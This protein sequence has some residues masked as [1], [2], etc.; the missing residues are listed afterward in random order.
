MSEVPD[1]GALGA[2]IGD[3]VGVGA[4][5]GAEAGD[6][7]GVPDGAGVA[8]GAGELGAAG[9]GAAGPGE[10]ADEAPGA[11]PVD[12]G[13]AFAEPLGLQAD[14]L[15]AQGAITKVIGPAA[16]GG[17]APDGAGVPYTGEGLAAGAG[18]A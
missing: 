18:E 11:P 15:G 8:V 4:L 16:A 12:T 7:V 14:S 6:G 5:D 10:L 2:K 9:V 3:A 13:V 17:A 1:A